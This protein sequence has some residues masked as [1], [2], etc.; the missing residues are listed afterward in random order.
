[1]ATVDAHDHP[2]P[3]PESTITRADSTAKSTVTQP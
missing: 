1:E 2:A 3:A